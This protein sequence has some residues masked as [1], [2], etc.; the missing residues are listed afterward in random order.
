MSKY[1]KLFFAMPIA[2]IVFLRLAK[3]EKSHEN[4]TRTDNHPGAD[5][6]LFACMR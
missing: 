2:L 5:F 4:L 6:P 1:P 3:K